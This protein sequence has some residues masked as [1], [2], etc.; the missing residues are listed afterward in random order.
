MNTK[1][2]L[3][4]L[5]GALI[6]FAISLLLMVVA[7]LVFLSTEDPDRAVGVIA[8]ISQAI[9]AFA[10]GFVAVWFYR[11]RG[12]VTGLYAGVLYLF[13]ILI[14]SFFFGG[15]YRVLPTV[16]LVLVGLLLSSFGGYLGLPT[17]KS[18]GAR[19]RAMR[20]RLG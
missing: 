19:R 13:L 16:L 5:R 18:V 1:Q 15:E 10:S 3:C 8:L 2:L 12:L 4:V 9:G 17:E 11:E 6:G 20:K 14:G 7:T